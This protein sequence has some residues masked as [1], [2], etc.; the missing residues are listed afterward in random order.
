[1]LAPRLGREPQEDEADEEDAGDGDDATE[2]AGISS[3]FGRDRN[4]N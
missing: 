4:R 1:L 3:Y 2:L